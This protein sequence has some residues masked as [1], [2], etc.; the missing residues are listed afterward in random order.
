MQTYTIVHRL[1]DLSKEIASCLDKTMLEN[2]GIRDDANP[3]VVF[4]IGGDGTFLYAVHQYMD[5]IE[6]IKFYGLHTGTL[7]FFTDYNDSEYETFVSQFLNDD[8]STVSFPLLKIDTGENVYYA[9][10]E[11]RIENV[12]RTQVLHISVDEDYFEEFRGT[13]ICFATQA[14]STAYN[15]SLGG[16]VIVEGMDAIVMSE[17]AGIH[18]SK[19]RSL[20]SSLVMKGD[21]CVTIESNDFSGAI[22]G[23]DSD[24]YSLENC[25]KIKVETSKEKKVNLLRCRN[26]SYFNRLKSLF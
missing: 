21:T 6:K 3:D 1:D 23:L 4:V 12:A 17:I 14:G 10:N 5:K 15:R 13:G 19:Y 26:I 8:L 22:L 20:G 24:V 11:M 2:S 18:H 7:G 25:K 16:A 9:L